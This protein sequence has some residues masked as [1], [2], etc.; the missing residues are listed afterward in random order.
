M[1]WRVEAEVQIATHWTRTLY[2]P[3]QTIPQV[4][5]KGRQKLLCGVPLHPQAQH[6][7]FIY[8]YWLLIMHIDLEY[9]CNPQLLQGLGTCC[10]NHGTLVAGA[11]FSAG[12]CSIMW[13][14]LLRVLSIY[15]SISSHNPHIPYMCHFPCLHT[16]WW[17]WA[18]AFARAN[19]SCT[20]CI[21]SHNDAYQMYACFCVDACML[22]P[23]KVPFDQ[24][25]PG[26]LATLAVS[27]VSRINTA[28]VTVSPEHFCQI[29]I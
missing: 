16:G 29:S 19:F 27:R 21:W 23:N 3:L 2:T 8:Y 17:F 15:G 28:R 6:F 1:Y 5:G 9:V 11:L 26:L 22:S 25:V 24:Y 18:G 7:V 10:R 12:S 14:I 4:G 20:L 13:D